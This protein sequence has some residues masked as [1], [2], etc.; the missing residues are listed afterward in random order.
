MNQDVNPY[1]SDD[2]RDSTHVPPELK[3][4]ARGGATVR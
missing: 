4:S 2:R 3:L 1:G